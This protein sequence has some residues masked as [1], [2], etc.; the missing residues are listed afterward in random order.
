LT[1]PGV[2]KGDVVADLRKKSDCAG[3]VAV[4]PVL[5]KTSNGLDSFACSAQETS[6]AC[7]T[8]KIPADD[9]SGIRGG[10]FDLRD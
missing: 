7:K 8:K 2:E 9:E 1:P 3:T 5:V 10:S 4:F 6:A